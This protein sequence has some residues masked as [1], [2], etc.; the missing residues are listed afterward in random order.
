M[1]KTIS[2]D[3]GPISLFFTR[4]HSKKI[5][6]LF[7]S[8]KTNQI[9]AIVIAPVLAEV[10]K[11]L[12][13]SNGKDYA[14]SSLISLLKFYPINVKS[15]DY[16]MILKAGQLKCQFRKKLSY[17][18]C[19]VIALALIEKCELHTTEKEFPTFSKLKIITYSF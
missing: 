12:C 3:T 9:N 11:H 7:N 13:V 19:F 16:S 15:L 6:A 10:F 18:D 14:N 2:L 1:N 8:I 4:D 5:D 17:I